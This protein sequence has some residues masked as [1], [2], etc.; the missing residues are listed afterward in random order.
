MADFGNLQSHHK[1]NE[2]LG[3]FNLSNSNLLN[4]S[5]LAATQK[6][7]TNQLIP[8]ASSS[9]TLN[10]QQ[11]MTPNTAN[12]LQTSS[13]NTQQLM[14]GITQPMNPT[15]RTNFQ[16]QPN[17][18]MLANNFKQ[19]GQQ[20]F[21]ISS[22]QPT[23][24]QMN[25]FPQQQGTRNFNQQ[26]RNMNNLQQQ[27]ANINFQNQVNLNYPQQYGKMNFQQQGGAM[28]FQMSGNQFRYQQ[29]QQQQQQQSNF[30]QPSNLN[31]M[32]Q[33]TSSR[34]SQSSD[35]FSFVQDAMKANKK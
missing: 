34:R 2:T 23:N 4:N 24:L 10:A 22:Q 5:N 21:N 12:Q 29:Q 27:G 15:N 35:A 28:N 25:K 1:S 26:Q 9:Y 7:S 33:G 11:P 30:G 20:S 32:N 31:F 6:P 14:T 3:G 17:T 18:Q 19:Q 13:M 8:S 16:T